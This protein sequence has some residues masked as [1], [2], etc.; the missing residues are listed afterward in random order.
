MS[1][2]HFSDHARSELERRRISQSDVL[3][4]LAHPDQ[5][6]PVR[7][8]RTIYQSQIAKGHPPKSY[9]LRVVVD[10]FEDDLIVVTAY[11]T[12]KVE[13]YWVS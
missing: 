10:R 2:V 11:Y 4:V 5:T 8:D 9:L 7:V 12:S 3:K 13:K 1:T 6:I